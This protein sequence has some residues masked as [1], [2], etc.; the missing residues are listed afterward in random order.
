MENKNE[1]SVVD[2]IANIVEHKAERSDFNLLIDNLNQ[3][4]EKH[5][6]DK[7]LIELE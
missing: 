1:V 6:I 5:E 7:V 2:K 3:K 4:A